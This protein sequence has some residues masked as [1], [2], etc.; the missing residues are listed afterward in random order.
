MLKMFI[1]NLKIY[2]NYE[3]SLDTYN[4]LFHDNI[5]RTYKCG[6]EDNISEINI[7]K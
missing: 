4:K 3:T 2:M 6:S 5:K 7:T 1:L